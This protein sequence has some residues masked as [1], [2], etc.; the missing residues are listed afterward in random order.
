MD[1]YRSIVNDVD[2]VHIWKYRN[3][4]FKRVN[5]NKLVDKPSLSNV[6]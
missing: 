1:L 6:N 2:T 4:C 3:L 5:Y